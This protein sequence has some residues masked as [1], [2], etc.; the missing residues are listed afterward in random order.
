M[1]G[2]AKA[3]LTVQMGPF[4]QFP[5]VASAA[6]KVPEIRFNLHHGVECGGAIGGKGSYCKAC[7]EDVEAE[8]I[9]H[10]YKGKPGVD[11]PYM[12]SLLFEKSP[13]LEV[14]RIVDASEIDPRFYQRSYSLIA[15]KGG[16]K[17]Y[18]MLLRVLDDADKVGVGKVIMG[19]KEFIVTLRPKDGVLAMELMFWPSEVLEDE[20]AKLAT[21]GV[22]VSEAE[23]AMGHKLVDF[24]TKPWEPDQ[25]VNR[26]FDAQS[27]YLDRF[28]ADEAPTVVEVPKREAPAGTDLAAQ[29]EAAMAAIGDTKKT[30]K[31]KKVAA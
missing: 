6:T 7:G 22:D 13:L 23:L 27:E 16:E 10:G 3:K 9:V 19:G 11:M 25:Y 4:V 18:V 15:E 8:E 2:A 17:A 30:K 5:V 21:E 1:A 31:T 24:L 28:L 14:D 20:Q 26:L 12:K 29:L